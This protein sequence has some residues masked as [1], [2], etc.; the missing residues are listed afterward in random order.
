MRNL[1]LALLLSL[2]VAGCS[3]LDAIS[4]VTGLFGDD[5]GDSVEVDT[6]LVG[7]DQ[8]A[9]TDVQ[10]GDRMDADVINNITDIPPYV[11]VLLVMGWVMPTPLAIVR[12]IRRRKSK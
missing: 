4:S 9:S 6:T 1:M 2:L 3:S 8:D 7:G 5:T 11:L 12:K 10:L